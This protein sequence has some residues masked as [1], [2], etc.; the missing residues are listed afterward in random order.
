M[1]GKGCGTALQSFLDQTCSGGGCELEL[2][3]GKHIL[4]SVV[5]VI[6]KQVSGGVV[7]M[8]KFRLD[9]HDSSRPN[10]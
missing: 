8:L 6:M 2:G 4:A 1:R 5:I 9:S 7:E 10:H 3:C